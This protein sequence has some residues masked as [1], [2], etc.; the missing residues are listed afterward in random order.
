MKK[1]KKLAIIT[2]HFWP[3]NFVINDISKYFSELGIK[4]T[5]IT[6]L[7]NYPD[8]YIFPKYQNIK[9]LSIS[10]LNKIKVLR[11]PII[12]RKKG[13]TIQLAINYL[14]FVFNGVFFLRNYKN[15]DFDHIFVFGTTPLT[16]ALLGIYLKKNLNLSFLYGYKIYGLT[17]SDHQDILKIIF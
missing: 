16:T 14:S 11:F 12:P 7:P 8:G 13:N 2:P 17:I 6:G 5:V 1:I 15:L 9:K 10:R 4:V 3:E